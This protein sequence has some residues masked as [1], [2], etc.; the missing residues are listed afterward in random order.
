MARKA[1]ALKN[2]DLPQEQAENERRVHDNAMCC[3]RHRDQPSAVCKDSR[4]AHLPSCRRGRA[5]RWRTKSLS[6]HSRKPHGNACIDGTHPRLAVGV[7]VA[8]HVHGLKHDGRMPKRHLHQSGQMCRVGKALQAQK[9][10][11]V[12]RCCALNTESGFKCHTARHSS[13][14]TTKTAC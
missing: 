9:V 10:G 3:L 7:T 11:H 13:A 6:H 8:V 5:G 4:C 14:R 1:N 12:A 2:G